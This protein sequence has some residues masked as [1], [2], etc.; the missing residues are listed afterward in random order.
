MRAQN[1]MLVVAGRNLLMVNS[2]YPGLDPEAGGQF[3]EV[4]WQPPP[5]R[6]FI[7]RITLTF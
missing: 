7:S 2:K 1:A 5:L 4:N 3:S 6:Y